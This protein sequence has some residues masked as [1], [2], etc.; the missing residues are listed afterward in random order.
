MSKK[1]KPIKY[2]Q[3]Q[4]GEWLTW[5]YLKEHYHTHSI[6]FD[7]GSVFD[8]TIGWRKKKYIVK[9]QETA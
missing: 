6:M 1:P 4:G 9:D 5:G 3:E 8:I 2:T 7:D